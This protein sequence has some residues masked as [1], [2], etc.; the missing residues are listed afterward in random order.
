MN[1]VILLTRWNNTESPKAKELCPSLHLG[2]TH[3]KDPQTQILDHKL[4]SPH[5]QLLKMP[6]THLKEPFPSRRIGGGAFGVKGWDTLHP[7]VQ[8]RESSLWPNFKLPLRGLKEEMKKSK[9]KS[10]MNL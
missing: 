9:N 1:L 7:N 10:P 2:L 4:H 8:T 5:G 6:K 3:F